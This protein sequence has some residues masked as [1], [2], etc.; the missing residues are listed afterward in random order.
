LSFLLLFLQGF[1]A[2][3]PDYKFIMNN[4][5][6]GC[7]KAIAVIEIVGTVSADSVIVEWSNG[8][9]QVKQIHDLESG[10]YFVR[11]YIKHKQDSVIS[12]KDTTLYFTIDV[13]QCAVLID[14]YF[15]PNDDNYHDLLYIN[16][17]EKYPNFEFIVYNKWGQR[18]HAQKKTYT[19]WDGKWAGV[20]LPDGTYYYVFFYNA[21]EKGKV[22]KGDLTI[23]R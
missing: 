1:L 23:L 14:K 22:V 20:D 4:T 7:L 3:Q 21:D 9:T 17:I 6:S 8:E 12:I 2:G 11:I 10:N 19:P 13:E 15:S 16:N 18:V 5:A